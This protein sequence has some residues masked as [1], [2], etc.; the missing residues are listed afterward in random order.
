M[1]VSAHSEPRC[2]AAA[3]SVEVCIS[4]R[5]RDLGDGFTVRRLLPAQAR[6]MVGPF[7]FFDHMGPVSLPPGRGL[8]VRPHPHI[9]LST[10]TYLF[11]GDILHRDSLGTEQPIRP[12]ELNWMTAG[13]GIVHSERSPGAA[14]N[15]DSR[16]HGL[17][18]WAALPREF[19]ETDPSFQHFAAAQLPEL[20]IPGARARL[21]AGK[22]FGETSPVQVHSPLFYVDVTL[23]KGA[24]LQLPD[25]Y[26]ERG[27]YVVDGEISCDGC[28]YRSGELL[29][30]HANA[31]A[32]IE[33]PAASRIM[34][35][36]GQPVD[37]TRLIWWNFVSSTRERM[38]RAR[39]DWRERRFPV[40]PGDEEE[41]IPLPEA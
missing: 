2:T 41:Y 1:S 11:E 8:D 5:A 27:L 39:R 13:R 19:E 29:V 24:A 31:P 18:L 37:G 23:D 40:V 7:I 28:S 12:G 21:V 10:V 35:L 3:D 25:E 34:L 6:Q 38:E 14:R 16:V 36:G 15:S 4:G 20:D 9:G 33:A 26:A 32:R 17:Q 30:F 22:A